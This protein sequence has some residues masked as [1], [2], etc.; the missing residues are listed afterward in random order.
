MRKIL[1]SLFLILIFTIIF[2]TISN[3]LNVNRIFKNIEENTGISIKLLEDKKWSYY[4]VIEYNN[5]LHIYNKNKNL[6][7]KKSHISIFK[8]YKL[9]SPFIIKFSSPSLTYKGVNFKNVKINSEYKS[10]YL[11]FTKLSANIIDGKTDIN[12]YLYLDD[13]KNIF[14]E[15]VYKNLSLNRL[16]K[17]LNIANWE[18]VKIKISSKKFSISSINDTPSLF[19]ENLNGQMKINGSIF[20]VST[21]EEKFSSAILSLLANKL[22]DI[23]ILSKS[24]NYLLDKFSDI[25]SN[26]SGNIQIKNGVLLTEKLLINNNKGKALLSGTLDLKTDIINGKLDLYKNNLIF[27]T[28]QI[29]GNINDPQILIG[30][31]NFLQKEDKNLININEIFKN[32][33]QSIIDNILEL[34]D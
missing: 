6:L 17:Q 7:V 20:F 33:M 1:I 4:P 5:N 3:K 16:L 10:K 24:I 19:I 25:P 12:G 31:N 30:E 2:L 22:P 11:K 13:T 28:S 18:R 15:G 27:L 9:T 26:I 8:D 29:Q 23:K 32:G 34:N 14:L 21:E